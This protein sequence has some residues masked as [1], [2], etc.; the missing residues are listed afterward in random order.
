MSSS[1]IPP[2][3]AE[4][5]E[6]TAQKKMRR[7]FFRGWLGAALFGF[8]LIILLAAYATLSNEGFRVAAI[9]TLGIIFALTISAVIWLIRYLYI[10][11]QAR[12]RHR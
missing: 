10:A 1:N 6:V 11:Q 9:V 2:P 7:R 4:N 3:G 5:K 8:G 12:N